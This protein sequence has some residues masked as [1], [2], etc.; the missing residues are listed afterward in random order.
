[1]AG[2]SFLY[3]SLAALSYNVGGIVGSRFI[4]VLL[5]V[6]T[7]EVVVF[8]ASLL[9]GFRDAR[10]FVGGLIAGS[11]VGGSTIALYIN[12]LATYDTPSFYL[13]FLGLAFM[14]WAEKKY[15]KNGKWYFLAF[16][17][18]YIA[19]LIKMITIAYIPLLFIISNFRSRKTKELYF[20]WK[21]YF[22]LPMVIGV[23]LYGVFGLAP[24]LTYMQSQLVRERIGFL[25]IVRL[26]WEKTSYVWLFYIIGTYGMLLFKQ[27][28]LWMMLTISALWIL[29]VHL[30]TFRLATLDKHAFLTIVFLS[31]VAGIGIGNLILSTTKKTIFAVNVFLWGIVFAGYWFLSYQDA[32]NYNTYWANSGEVLSYLSS[33]VKL[34]DTILAEVGP[35]AI[36]SVY[37]KNHPVYT[38]T[39]DWFEYGKL[40]G[41][42][43]YAQAVQD[44][45]FSYIELEEGPDRSSEKVELHNLIQEN[46]AD[47]Y[48]IVYDNNGFL[49]YKRVY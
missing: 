1:M 11:I 44:G 22:A 16:V 15:V 7:V 35:A 28:K 19:F 46:L 37:E 40:Q 27:W 24:T 34:G 29:A 17:A 47:N 12:R 42:E 5:G 6:L 48:N 9:S 31:I 20:Y 32:K 49:V 4:N 43:A 10:K 25:E 18:L 33:E 14:F 3:P 21:R 26:F 38:T 8:L 23:L 41:P 13:F 2:S 45:Y 30:A 39:F 36:L